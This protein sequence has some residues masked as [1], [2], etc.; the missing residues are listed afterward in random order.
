[1]IVLEKSFASFPYGAGIAAV[2]R[3][4][5]DLLR[6]IHRS[7]RGHE[8]VS[9]QYVEKQMQGGQVFNKFFNFEIF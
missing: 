6:L 5:G 2:L 4:L 3:R 9:K 7:Q 1:M 8:D